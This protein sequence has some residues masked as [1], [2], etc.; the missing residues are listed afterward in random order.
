MA[1]DARQLA[2]AGVGQVAVRLGGDSIEDAVA[3]I[4]RFGAEVIANSG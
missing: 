2:A 4:E 3:R 1:D